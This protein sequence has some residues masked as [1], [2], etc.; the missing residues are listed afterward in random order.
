MFAMSTLVGTPVV[1]PVKAVR[2]VRS[3]R[4]NAL[5]GKTKPAKKTVAKAKA[6]VC[7]SPV[8]SSTWHW[9]L[10][11]DRGRRGVRLK[12]PRRRRGF[13]RG[14][15]RT[16]LR[17]ASRVFT[18]TRGVDRARDADKRARAAPHESRLREGLLSSPPTQEPG[19]VSRGADRG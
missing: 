7:F 13:V 14:I 12:A 2:A 1:A 19:F 5:F 16:D 8:F 11:V 3:T 17:P 9:F 15:A 18:I 6:K 10:L 4:V